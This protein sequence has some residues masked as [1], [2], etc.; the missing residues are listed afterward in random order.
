V[1]HLD[2]LR[3]YRDRLAGATLSVTS[4]RD[5]V[6][7][8]ALHIEDALAALPVVRS[9]AVAA[10]IDVGSGGGSP[11][12]P[13][14]IETGLPVTLLEARAPKA[15]FLRQVVRD[16]DLPCEVLHARSEWLARGSGRDHW[17]MAVARALAPPPAAVELS[18]PLV[19][20]GG[21]LVL[22]VAARDLDA[23][24]AMAPLLAGRL[25]ES[26]P[27]P[28]ARA[29][30]VVEKLGPTPGQFPRRPGAAR[31]RP[32]PSLRSPV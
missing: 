22:W 15:A 7:A 3:A 13:L 29:L 32:P 6:G 11:G 16:L 12:I 1:K 5:P 8:W 4:V 10:I 17:D 9:R 31:R 2:L 21:A 24:E 19:R 27:R 26:R 25:V 18:L 28:D 30:A 20:P 23:V 14:A